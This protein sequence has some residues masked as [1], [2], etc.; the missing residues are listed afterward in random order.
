MEASRQAICPSELR[1][2]WMRLRNFKGISDM[3]ISPVGDDTDVFGDNAT[4]K[5]TLFDAFTWL[6]FD[7][8]SANRSTFSVKTLTGA[9]LVENP[10]LDHEVEAM[11]LWNAARI[12][13]KKVYSER[14]TKKRGSAERQFEG[15]TTDYYVDD[16]PVKLAEYKAK[17][18]EI[19]D[20]GVFRLLTDPSFFNT[21]L[22]WEKQRRPLLLEVCGNLTDADVISS[23][24][25]LAALPEILGD[26]TQADHKK[27]IEARRREI[28][29]ELEK[30]PTRI[31]EVSLG[32]PDI[33]GLVRETI[34]ADLK[35]IRTQAQ[36]KHQERARVEAGGE[37]AE[38]MK[39]ISKGQAEL[40]DIETRIRREVE[41]DGAG[42]RQKRAD[43]SNRIEDRNRKAR[44]KNQDIE[45]NK[46]TISRLESEME[47]LREE[48]HTIDSREFND[49]TETVC[50]TCEQDLPHE[51]VDSARDKA[52]ASFN[53]AKAQAL[54]NNVEAGKQA[55]SQAGALSLDNDRLRKE[56]EALEADAD[57][58][59]SELQ[60]L[61]E[62]DGEAATIAFADYP[63][64][65][66]K[67][68]E[69]A[70]LEAQ[71]TELS[72]GNSDALAA[73]DAD[74]A[75]LKARIAD[76]EAGLAKLDQHFRGQQRI[77]ELSDQEKKLSAEFEQLEKE[78]FLCES[79]TKTK[80]SLLTE[81][82]NG[83]FKLARFKL[84]NELINGGVE[85]CCETTFD[86]VPYSDLNNGARINVGLDIINTLSEHY[87]FSAPIFV[88]NAEAVTT[89]S[90][91]RGQL[92][93]L[94]VSESDKQLRVETKTELQEVVNG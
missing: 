12:K 57:E 75:D 65:D 86:G 87:G 24:K 59:G 40:V 25:A 52:L 88:D 71:K 80:V 11:L 79:F 33:T 91:T 14:W 9:G 82:I 16:V 2:D 56:I 32:Q 78:L 23:D 92:I 26:R 29:K 55:Q 19:C 7:K 70:A 63:E 73:V 8:D 18:A 42:V 49:T 68:G 27:V 10:G 41:G 74:I 54:E 35:T 89:L 22:H 48:W 72:E 51:K 67:T 43:L 62:V 5:T 38:K 85:D 4:G 77:E 46:A 58:S 37:V 47:K 64:W 93:R 3:K 13:L 90:E 20:E 39:L 30:L 53:S 76:G 6:L 61:P 17:V 94:V 66:E 69:I 60:A 1:I 81:R 15:N 50:P 44:S 21:Q 34:E 36:D 84:F 31:D 45:S 28:N 83:K